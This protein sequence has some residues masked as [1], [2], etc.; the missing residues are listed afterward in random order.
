MLAPPSVPNTLAG[1]KLRNDCD[2]QL[3]MVIRFLKNISSIEQTMGGQ[4]LRCDVTLSVDYNQR[5]IQT[6]S[7]IQSYKILNMPRDGDCVMP[8]L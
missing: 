3:L 2:L 5:D 6:V 1:K 8:T 4:R 7:I